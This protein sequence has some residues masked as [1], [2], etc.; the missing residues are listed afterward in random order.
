MAYG[1][2]VPLRF[3][4]DGRSLIYIGRTGNAVDFWLL[5]L[6]TGSTR[7]LTHL[8]NP[9]TISSFDVTPDAKQIVFDRVRENSDIWLI[10][11]PKP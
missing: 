7:Q 6:A 10:D 3:L 11:L 4:P 1:E 8:E 9:D 2:G 5:D